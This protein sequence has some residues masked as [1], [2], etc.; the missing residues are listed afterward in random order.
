MCH[1]LSLF[2]C[3][4]LRTVSIRFNLIWWYALSLTTCILCTMLL[5]VTL[6]L[7]MRDLVVSKF[8]NSQYCKLCDALD[9]QFTHWW[10]TV[11]A[12]I[13]I[14]VGYN[15]KKHYQYRYVPFF[16][17]FCSSHWHSICGLVDYLLLFLN[18]DFVKCLCNATKTISTLRCWWLLQLLFKSQNTRSCQI[19]HF[20]STRHMTKISK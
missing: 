15:P 12:Y 8:Y 2:F 5:I 7:R 13:E 3:P 14:K 17:S 18:L 9:A 6:M 4:K 19:R 16:S 11:D 10:S 1:E 20:F